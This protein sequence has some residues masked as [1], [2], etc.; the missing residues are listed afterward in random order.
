MDDSKMASRCDMEVGK[1]VDAG[2]TVSDLLVSR[3]DKCIVGLAGTIRGQ[4]V[5]CESTTFEKANDFKAHDER[6]RAVVISV[7]GIE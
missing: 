3:D 5:V 6:V 2:S 7:Y 4:I 1:S